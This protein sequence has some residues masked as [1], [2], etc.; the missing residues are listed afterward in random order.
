[1]VKKLVEMREKVKAELEYIPRHNFPQNILRTVYWA[2]RMHS[3]GKK[4]KFNETKE[5]VLKK[6]IELVQKDYPN[7]VPE[8]DKECH[9]RPST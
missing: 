7:F 4:A 2:G 6:S 5:E 8:Y 3:L 9:L 1:M